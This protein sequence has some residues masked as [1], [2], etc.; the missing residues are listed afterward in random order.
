MKNT[1]LVDPIRKKSIC[2]NDLVLGMYV[3]EP[4]G[5]WTPIGTVTTKRVATR[6]KPDPNCPCTNCRK[7][8]NS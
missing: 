6:R 8:R 4:D 1:Y 5:I 7:K 2:V 3:A